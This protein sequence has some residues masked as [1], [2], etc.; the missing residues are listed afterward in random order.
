MPRCFLL[1]VFSS[2][3]RRY[4]GN[5]RDL[6]QRHP[7]HL[8]NNEKDLPPLQR[9]NNSEIEMQG[10]GISTDSHHYSFWINQPFFLLFKIQMGCMSIVQFS[11]ELRHLL[12]I[13][14]RNCHWERTFLKRKSRSSVRR[15]LIV[16][17]RK[18]ERNHVDFY[19][20]RIKGTVSD[21]QLIVNSCERKKCESVVRW[22]LD[23]PDSPAKECPS[24]FQVA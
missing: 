11:A 2:K 4:T 18:S 20:A 16:T 23:F 19:S 9:N 15:H 13:F 12:W 1:L 22:R 8:L 3:K 5:E 7:S 24:C 17:W 6:I 21:K 14:Q 10:K